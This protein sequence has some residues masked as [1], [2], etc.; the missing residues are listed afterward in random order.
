MKKLILLLAITTP[1][2]AQKPDSLR[3]RKQSPNY[4]GSSSLSA[5][6]LDLGEKKDLVEA[7]LRAMGIPPGEG[8]VIHSYSLELAFNKTTCI[9]FKSPIRSVDLGSRDIMADKASEVENVLRIKATRIGFNET[10]FSVMTADGKFYSFIANYNESPSVLALNLA[11][12]MERA[13]QSSHPVSTSGQVQT[14]V[15][16]AGTQTTQRELVESCAA[17]MRQR[18]RI[19]HRGIGKREYGMAVSLRGLYVKDNVLYYKIALRNTSNIKYDLDFIR[20][21]I[22]DKA[23]ARQTSRQELEVSPLYIYNSPLVVVGGKQT[24]EKVFAFSKFTIP[25]GKVLQVRVGEKNGGRT[26]A[27]Q[28]NNRRLVKATT[29]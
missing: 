23:L 22:R 2:L 12:G 26:V 25:N 6:I 17:V 1:L 16:Y 5:P 19:R 21:F 24:V 28:V 27:F 20:F 14:P 29:L 15:E 4:D 18:G 3:F 8:S 11:V 9:L 10:N 13:E 7:S